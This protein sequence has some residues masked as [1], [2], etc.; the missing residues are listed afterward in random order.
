[1]SYYVNKNCPVCGGA[2]KIFTNKE[3]CEE[4]GHVLPGPTWAT[5]ATDT[6]QWK[7]YNPLKES[8]INESDKSTSTQI[9]DES[10][11]NIGGLYGW[12][13]PKCG[14]VM[15]PYQS[16]CPNCTHRS[17]EITCSTNTTGSIGDKK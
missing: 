12:I 10:N 2:V 17:W 1:M 11:K 5:T 3:I 13:C 8:N 7:T 9:V 4:C 16:F 14:A 15:S 6:T